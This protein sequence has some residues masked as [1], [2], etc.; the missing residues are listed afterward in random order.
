MRLA[1]FVPSVLISSQINLGWSPYDRGQVSEYVLLRWKERKRQPMD[2]KVSTTPNAERRLDLDWV[3]IIA[4]ALLI[5]YHVTSFYAAITPHNQALSP[6]V[7]DWLV[8]PM[9][10]LSPW[11]LLILFIVSGAATRFMADKM[12]PKALRR[13]RTARLL[14]PLIFVTAIIVPPISFVTVEQ[15]YGYQ[16]NFLDFLGRYFT[17]DNHF[18]Q[19]GH[20][21]PV[22]FPNPFH[23][24]FVVYLWIYTMLLIGLLAWTPAALRALQRALEQ[25]LGGWGLIVWPAAYLA[26]S[27]FVLQ[28]RFPQ[29]LDLIHDWYNHAV[30]FGGFLLGFAVAK[31][32]RIW[33]ALEHLRARTLIGALVSYTIIGAYVASTLQGG[34]VN[35]APPGMPLRVAGAVIGGSEQ[36]LCIAAVFGFAHRYLSE[37]DGPVRRYLTDAIFPFYIIHMLTV[38]VGGYYLTRLELDLRLEYALLIAATTLSCFVTYEIVRRVAWLRPWFG[39]KR[40]PVSMRWPSRLKSAP[41]GV[42][43]EDD[44]N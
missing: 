29:T 30:Y 1:T 36:W 8:I 19:A 6:R 5:W 13:A 28:S 23:L 10:A 2:S 31:S 14:P 38:V 21:M 37:R 27:S 24:W 22:P 35:S 40:L 16:G 32:D 25:A 17:A 41:A 43:I 15:W 12:K 44:T 11:R 42:R 34:A 20:C 3:R 18:C 26:L 39:L 33:T 9:L 7:Y 4:F